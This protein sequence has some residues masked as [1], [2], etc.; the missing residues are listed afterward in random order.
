MFYRLPKELKKLKNKEVT[1]NEVLRYYDESRNIKHKN[2]AK[3]IWQTKRN[4]KR[5]ESGQEP[6]DK[7]NLDAAF[8]RNL[9][10]LGQKKEEQKKEKE[11]N[12]KKRQITKQYEQKQRDDLNPGK[13][14]RY[15]ESRTW[16]ER[17]NKTK[18][19]QLSKQH[20][21]SINALTPEERDRLVEESLNEES[22]FV[23][24]KK[25]GRKTRKR[26]RS[27]KRRKTRR[28]KNKRRRKRKTRRKRAGKST[29]I[30][31]SKIDKGIQGCNTLRRIPEIN[32]CRNMGGLEN[33]NKKKN[34]RKNTSTSF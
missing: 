7:E 30:K 16:R 4:K 19:S 28:K 29:F 31:Q 1:L 22:L 34:D 13:G 10:R 18:K 6:E 27:R 23:R 15:R 11:F 21:Q 33:Y 26:R 12:K 25:G 24:E 14:I 5:K 8:N 3:K 20:H 9:K 2:M 17:N 32:K